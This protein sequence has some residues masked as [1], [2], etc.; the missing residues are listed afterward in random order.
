THTNFADALRQKGR[1]EE[2]AAAYNE[3]LLIQPA[4]AQTRNNLGMTLAA[5]GRSRDAIAEFRRAIGADPRLRAAHYNLASG[6]AR[7]GHASGAIAPFRAAFPEGDERALIDL[8]RSPEGAEV[9]NNLGLALLRSG[10]RTAGIALL[11][12]AVAANPQHA[13]SQL[14]LASALVLE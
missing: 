13:P 11:Q 7:A 14:N 8:E 10:G 6:L 9:L 2:A 5:L 3:A 4:S 12:R 1:L